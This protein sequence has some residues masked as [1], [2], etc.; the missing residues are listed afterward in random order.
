MDN[1]KLWLRFEDGVEGTVDL[2]HLAGKGIFSFWNDSDNFKKVHIG[3]YGEIIWSKEVEICG[4][5]LYLQITGKKPEEIF[6]QEERLS[7]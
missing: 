1:Y 3:K 2:S 5:N 4:D 7:A 6:R